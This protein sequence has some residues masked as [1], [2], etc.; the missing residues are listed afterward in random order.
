MYSSLFFL[1]PYAYECTWLGFVC[2]SMYS[3]FCCAIL[4]RWMHLI[5]FV[6]TSIH[7][8]VYHFMH[9]TAL[10]CPW[11][12]LYLY[13]VC[14]K[15]LCTW[16]CCLKLYALVGICNQG[17][18]NSVL[19]GLLC[20]DLCSWC[21]CLTSWGIQ[22]SATC[23]CNIA[24]LR[25]CIIATLHLFHCNIASVSLPHCSINICFI[26]TNLVVSI[27]SHILH[28][29]S[30]SCFLSSLHQL[31]VVGNELRRNACWFHAWYFTQYG[32]SFKRYKPV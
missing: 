2:T 19:F 11:I 15:G 25:H 32:L 23:H 17:P 7:F 6:C 21:S 13:G 16:T 9:L 31:Y 29:M 18:L 22:C 8:F 28:L 14:I 27:Q 3:S 20:N 4:C 1:Q 12:S 24:T 10:P 30:A 5:R 26:A